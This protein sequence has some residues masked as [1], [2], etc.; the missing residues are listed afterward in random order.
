MLSRPG[1][2]PKGPG[3]SFEVKWDGFRALIST[4]D[5]FRV[6]S[7]RGWN[8]TPALPELGRLPAGLV[9]DGELIAFNEQATPISRCCAG[10][11]STATALCRCG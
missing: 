9:L 1:P 3:W 8:M 6:R 4:V 5:G 7:R 2:L 11:C 10:G